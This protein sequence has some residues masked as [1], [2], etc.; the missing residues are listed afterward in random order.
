MLKRYIL[1]LAIFVIVL[2]FFQ[3]A[4][5]EGPMWG[6]DILVHQANH[7]YGF[8]M[9]QGDKDTLYL[10]VA[11]S[12][13]TNST[14]TTYI[15]R[16]TDNGN[17]WS[18]RGTYYSGRR[19]KADIIAAKGD[20]NAVY[21]FQ[22]F[23]Q[24]LYCSR[25]SYD[26]SQLHLS[27]YISDVGEDVVDFKVCQDL[28]SN[29][30][31][32]VVYQTDEDS[33]IFKR[34]RNFDTTWTDRANL[35]ATTPIRSKPSV[36][37]SRGTYIVVA[38]KTADDKIYTIRNTNSGN[39][40]DWQDGQYPSGLVDC[41]NPTV[42][43]SHTSPADSA[44]F[45][46]FYERYLTLPDPHWILNFHWST[47]A[48]ATW[49]SISSPNDTSSGNRVLPSLH[50]L[51]EN[52]VSNLTLAYRYEIGAEPRQIRY[53]YKQNAQSTPSVWTVSYTGVNDYDP[54]YSPPH[55]AYTI[56]GTD[57]S[58]GSAILYVRSPYED[59]YFDASSFTGVD[60]V[61]EERTIRGFTLDQNYPN[62]FNPTTKIGFALSKSG[63]VRLEIFNILGE[64][65]KTLADQTLK[66]GHQTIEW[67][68]KDDSGEE[69]AS[70]IYLYRLQTKDFTQTKKM[71]LI[72]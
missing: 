57:N 11:D 30:W 23:N 47:N 32:Y 55:R 19:G 4:M 35:S 27:T 41:D 22:I 70:G 52:D 72:K 58:V 28:F 54:D 8:G 37:W 53:I 51:K 24:R 39:S 71:V 46:V 18:W 16:S 43:G 3:Q 59:L 2:S 26:F 14:D 65:V 9:D 25:R 49:Y 42:A 44:I 45:W 20:L 60:E 56:R 61:R 33:V 40:A 21:L 6:N 48:G 29:Y 68:G 13:T 15:Y 31:L 7:I 10:I 50:V 64:R 38:G 69:V 63:Q 5:A 67:D 66:A 62:P 34:S 12:S 36:A 1:V 17:S